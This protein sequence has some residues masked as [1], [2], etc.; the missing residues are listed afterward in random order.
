MYRRITKTAVIIALA[1]TVVLCTTFTASAVSPDKIFNYPISKPQVGEDIAYIE[2]L[3]NYNGNLT[4]EVIYIHMSF[5]RQ[6]DTEFPNADPFILL[7]VTSN[8]LEIYSADMVIEPDFFGFVCRPNGQVVYF[9]DYNNRVN[10]GYQSIVGIHI[11]GDIEFS[12]PPSETIFNTEF[13]CNYGT[14]SLSH[15]QLNTIISILQQQNN[16]DI[17]ESFDQNTDEIKNNQDKNTQDVIDNQNQIVENEKEEINSSG[18]GSTNAILDAIPDIGFD[19]LIT[20]LSNIVSSV[21]DEKGSPCNIDFPSLKIPKINGVIPNEITLTPV[22]KIDLSYWVS[23]I[24]YKLITIVRSLDTIAIVL[25]VV[26]E[27][28]SLILYCL[29]LKNNQ[30]GKEDGID[31]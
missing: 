21:S 19:S 13:V 4:S 29:T 8:K 15:S 11:Y 7:T 25:Y 6:Y 9:E 23:Q 22:Y 30:V 1:V 31:E 12:I 5:Y 17:V 24:P 27:L 16:N 20:G 26:Y 18:N 3:H 10:F 28:Y 14:D 2:I